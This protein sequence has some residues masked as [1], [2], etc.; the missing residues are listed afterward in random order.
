MLLTAELL[1]SRA[2]EL[3]RLGQL[4]VE[5]LNFEPK[6]LGGLV[7]DATA[8]RSFLCVFVVDSPCHPCK[9]GPC[10]A[11]GRLALFAEQLAL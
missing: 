5:R 8:R 11:V 7:A 9:D 6:L 1:Q 3:V 4:V 2:V 10:D